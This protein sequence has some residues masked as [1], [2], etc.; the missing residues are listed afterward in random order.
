MVE[1]PSGPTDGFAFIAFADPVPGRLGAL[2]TKLGVPEVARW[3][4]GDIRQYRQGEI[5]FLVDERPDGFAAR[6]AHAHGPC[7]YGLGLRVADA[8]G[9][10][11]RLAAA[12][13]SPVEAAAG[14]LPFPAI[15]GVGGL[16]LYLADRAL[17]AAVLQDGFEVRRDAEAVMRSADAGL[18]DV[19]HVT[20][21]LERGGI[22]RWRSYYERFFGFRELRS[23]DIEGR[24]TGLV[25]T[26]MVSPCGRIRIP[27]NE[28]KGLVDE[29]DQVEEF[30]H[31][32]R[33]PGIQH[34]ALSSR[35]LLASVDTL[36][37]RGVE[38]QDTSDSY[39]DGMDSRLP[40]HGLRVEDLRR[41]RVLVDG[42]VEA[43][44]PCLLLQIFG[45]PAIGPIFFEFIER[46]GDDG[47]GEG[48]FKAL[49]ESL[50][51]DQIRRGVLS[52]DA[53]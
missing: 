37:G 17:E 24:V 42:R 27:L 21:N 8:A 15:E 36:T 3:R 40:G 23:F 28:S 12:G 41:R 20:H 9:A 4:H 49:F 5:V 18:L 25:S 34:I 2:F 29:P 22:A 52:A 1:P 38:L 19:D 14:E 39:F 10:L 44:S 16:R 43:G 13:A 50:E 51:L 33:G 46:R 6:F 48:N 7:A 53:L 47:F 11:D 31:A 26:A 30:L 45:Q 35:D 32:Y